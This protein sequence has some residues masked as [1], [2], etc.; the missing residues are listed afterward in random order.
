MPSR[1]TAPIAGAVFVSSPPP[2]NTPPSPAGGV[3]APAPIRG[4]SSRAWPRLLLAAAEQA[5]LAG[6]G[7]DRADADP[8]VVER[9]VAASDRPLDEAGLDLRYRVDQP[10]VRGHVDHVE[11]AG[12]EHH[13]DLLGAGQVGEE[14]G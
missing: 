11:G 4:V 9:R 8:R 7:V 6:V 14:L 3:I 2:P 1:R 13:R 5:A 12:G 10:D